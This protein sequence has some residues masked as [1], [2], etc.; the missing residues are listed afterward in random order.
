MLPSA[1]NITA[2][3]I[4]KRKITEIDCAISSSS[5]PMTGAVA[6]MAEPPQMDEPTPTSMALFSRTPRMRY[7]I[8]AVISD[9]EIV[10]MIIGRD[11]LPM[12]AT[13]RRFM[14]KPRKT[15]ADWRIFLIRRTRPAG[16][17]FCL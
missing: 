11:V 17:G 9:V 6:A 15:I 10:A 2:A 7:I 14:E 4:L 5:A 1:G 8:Y 3:I 16:P 13:S 12:M